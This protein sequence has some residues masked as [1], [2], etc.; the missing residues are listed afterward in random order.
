MDCA[1]M[2]EGVTEII[3][4]LCE[5]TRSYESGGSCVDA[6]FALEDMLDVVAG[7]DIMHGKV[8]YLST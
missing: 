6:R 8:E 1:I 5:E 3:R 2:V 7:L 4:E